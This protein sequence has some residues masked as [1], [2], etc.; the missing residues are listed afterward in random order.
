MVENLRDN[1]N[2]LKATNEKIKEA[3]LKAEEASEAKSTFLANMSHEIRTPLNA[4]LGFTDL[5]KGTDLDMLQREYI[6]TVHGSGE[7]LLALINDILDISKIEANSIVLESIVFDFYYLIESILKMVRSKIQGRPIELIYNIQE[8]M[9]TSFKGD[10]TRIRQI[11]INFIGNA[12][13]FTERGDIIIDI[14]LDKENRG[15]SHRT[16]LFVIK[17]NGIGIPEDQ[18]QKIFESF[19]QADTSTTRKY[20]GTGLGLNI[21]KAFIERMGGRVWVESEVG[22][23]STFYFTLLLEESDRLI[24]K[25]IKPVASKQLSGTK[26]IIVDDNNN[27]RQLLNKYCESAGIVI[28]KS[29]ISAKEAIEWLNE[30]EELPDVVL[31]DIMMPVIDVYEFIKQI[32]AAENTRNLEVISVTSDAM[33]GTSKKAKAKGFDGYIGK[34]I[35]KNELINVI[36][37]V[38]GDKREGGQIV[39][40]HLAE[41]IALKGIRVLVV[42]DNEVNLKLAVTLLKKMGCEVFTARD[43]R[44]AINKVREDSYDIVLMDLHMPDIN[45]LEATRTIR[46]EI[47]TEIPIIA[48]TATA[49]KEDEEKAFESGMNDFL[50]KPI[51]LKK[52]NKKMRYWVEKYS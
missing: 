48:L 1:I 8:D 45:G 22:K 21:S 32:R 41:E 16:V 31:T 14:S 25:D 44:E 13:K 24:D 47:D 52:L 19:T 15:S 51:N 20:G 35:I 39:T 37:T 5:L 28:L 36:R 18:Q 7:A 12:L 26:V 33:A 10:P 3:Q 38:I 29:F 46:Y 30:T 50:T 4:I 27:A 9:P 11:L 49:M 2:E 17:D 43:G 40:R 34:P 42:E 23:G 6:E